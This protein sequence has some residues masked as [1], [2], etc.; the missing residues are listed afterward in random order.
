MKESVRDVC[1]LRDQS[2]CAVEQ[3]NLTPTPAQHNPYPYAY[4][5]AYAYP[6][7]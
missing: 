5:Y 6:Y 4:A 1:W 2:M 7:P 3:H